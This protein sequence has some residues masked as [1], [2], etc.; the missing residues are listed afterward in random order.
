MDSRF[1]QLLEMAKVYR[2]PG[3]RVIRY[4]YIPE[5]FNLFRRNVK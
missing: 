2:M 5:F 1:K 3:D 4:I